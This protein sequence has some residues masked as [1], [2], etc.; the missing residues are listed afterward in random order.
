[1][2]CGLR[3][4]A[5][6]GVSSL[7]RFLALA[8]VLLCA[9]C[10]QTSEPSDTTGQSGCVTDLSCPYGEECIGAGCAPIAA[11]LFPHI[12]TASTMH[13]GPL[14]DNE[15]T[16][17]AQHFDLLVG[18]IRADVMRGA[19]P[20]VRMFEYVI[21]R[22]HRFDDGTKTAWDWGLAHGYNP[23][24]FYLHY[25]EDV[26]L[27]TWESTVVVPGF[28][29]GRVPGWNPGG[30]GNPASATSRDQ[31]RVVGYNYNSGVPWYFANI[32]HPGYREFLAH[33]VAGLIDG[34]WYFNQPFASG[35]IDGVMVDE[36]IWYPLFGEGLLDH[37]NEYYGTPVTD[38]HPYTYAIESVF[39]SLAQD[40][41]DEFA[42]TKDIM[43]NY[44]HVLFLNY[45]N[46]CAQNIQSTTPWIYGEVW[47][48]YTGTSSPTSGGN[49]CITYDNDYVQAVREI[50]R[51]TKRGGRRVLGG[52]D[53]AN[54]PSGT[55]R[56]KMLTLGL[57][58]LVHNEHTYYQYESASTFSSS[59]V[60]T[61]AWNPAV[62]Y[63][64]GVP[65]VIP[66]GAIDFE[67]NANTKEHYLFASG[68]DPV[69]PS[70]TYRV[71]ARRYTN[72]LVLVKLLPA[73]STVDDS[74]ITTHALGGT[75]GVL[76]ADGLVDPTP[77]TQ[78]SI[79]NNEAL[80]L[81]P[82]D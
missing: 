41:M 4:T 42:S 47:V 72:A 11:S 55:D 56:G 28:P 44:G 15:A 53:T 52:R 34:T 14:D 43:P 31:S 69:N 35:P 77:I 62:P 33:H 74:S 57:Y 3:S 36:A 27:P 76:Q 22:Y 12:Q 78:A 49:R 10:S 21:A 37:S 59:H 18:G 68:A 82:L 1:M 60:S 66:S 19:N 64:V 38:G 5:V 48:S 63:D 25:R 32:N 79:R 45:P 24:D 73:G 29:P 13:R 17:R 54:G 65:D 9:A 58:Y 26:D 46:R 2:R 7:A 16:W 61:W 75:Y 8:A 51:Q 6:L 67:G 23:E 50:V 81:I 70:L 30:G 71:L 39:P 40:M 20:N 80:I